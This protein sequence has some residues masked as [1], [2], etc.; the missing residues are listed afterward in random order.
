M[1]ERKNIFLKAATVTLFM[2][3]FAFRR[4]ETAELSAP[5]RL[6]DDLLRNYGSP[7]VRPVRNHTNIVNVYFRPR[8]VWF[9]DFD[10]SKQV[11]SFVSTNK[12]EWTDEYLT[13]NPD[14][15][16]GIEKITL[17]KDQ[18]WFPDIITF[19]RVGNG[20]AEA[21]MEDTFVTADY[22]GNLVY[23]N[24]VFLSVF[25]KMDVRLFPYDTH[26]CPARFLSFAYEGDAVAVFIAND[27]DSSETA[28]KNNGVWAV[29]HYHFEE[30]KIKYPCCPIPYREVHFTMDIR[31]ESGFYVLNVGIPTLL[32]S[33]TTLSVFLLHPE[34][35]EKISLCVNNVL[36][37]II[38]Q[39]LLTMNMPPTGDQT[40]IVAYYFAVV[41][42]ISFLSVLTTCVTLSIY[43]TKT[44]RPL[45]GL[46][47]QVLLIGGRNSS[48]RSLQ[49]TK[50]EVSMPKKTEGLLRN[51]RCMEA[52]G[53]EF[54]SFDSAVQAP[55]M[56]DRRSSKGDSNRGTNNSMGTMDGSTP[57]TMPGSDDTDDE[58]AGASFETEW[59]KAAIRIDVILFI[60]ALSAMI[61][62]ALSCAMLFKFHKPDHDHDELETG[63]EDH[64]D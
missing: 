56:S 35:G 16:D 3:Q 38:F 15:Y 11:L 48:H 30:V 29:A 50:L 45:P 14:D 52:R 19:E 39:Q 55:G 28:L 6:A 43:H 13:W 32:L 37:W 22:R 25:C 42:T 61:L 51:S 24:L 63:D 7:F 33:L 59:V 46:L 64:H 23:Y 57:L 17:G 10:E 49:P 53:H 54:S 21:N 41:I 9:A 47:R 26:S 34:C 40:P 62:A 58:T 8:P 20:P 31:R 18:I 27:S 1:D 5:K 44:N 2:V 12:Y 4:G 36:A 60:L